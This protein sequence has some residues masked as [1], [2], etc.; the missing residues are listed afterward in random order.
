M[1]SNEAFE[2]EIRRLQYLE[3]MGVD[4]YIPR[5]VLPGALPSVVLDW[6]EPSVAPLST[7]SST[8]VADKNALQKLQ[9]DLGVPQRKGP[10]ASRDVNVTTPNAVPAKTS[11]ATASVMQC[12]LAI[13]QPVHDLLVL[14]PAQHTH[15][16]HLQLLKNILLAIAVKTDHLVPLDNFIWPPRVVGPVKINPALE[17]AQETLHSL[18]EG[19]QLKY[20]TKNILV[21]AGALAERLFPTEANVLCLPDLQQMLEDGAYKKITWHKIRSLVP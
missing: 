12:Q 16:V 9:Q 5:Q 7:V 2:K 8:A 21:F 6:P 10:A 15:A 3:A 18:L 1:P 4:S 11:S 17:A 14:V 13:F 20:H 19:Y